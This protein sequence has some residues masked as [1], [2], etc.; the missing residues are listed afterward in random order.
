[1]KKDTY[2]H[3]PI[4]LNTK[5]G[6]VIKKFLKTVKR[7]KA[8]SLLWCSYGQ[9]WEFTT[10]ANFHFFLCLGLCTLGP[11]KGWGCSPF[12]FWCVAAQGP[13]EW[14]GTITAWNDFVS[15]C[16]Y[17]YIEPQFLHLEFTPDRLVDV[18]RVMAQSCTCIWISSASVKSAQNGVA[19]DCV[20][21]EDAGDPGLWSSEAQSLAVT[22]TCLVCW[23][24]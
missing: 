21:G 24:L 23:L 13:W 22:Q 14:F 7:K 16:W 1:M 19:A 12:P 17:R 10:S 6:L 18:P 15:V 5:N 4:N 20:G 2:T 11:S 3:K 9:E 8:L